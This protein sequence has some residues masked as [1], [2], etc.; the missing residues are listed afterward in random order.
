MHLHTKFLLI[1]TVCIMTVTSVCLYFL[2]HNNPENASY[3]QIA[4][5]DTAEIFKYESG[6]NTTWPTHTLQAE[7]HTFHLNYPNDLQTIIPTLEEPAITLEES[8]RFDACIKDLK[9]TGIENYI[10]DPEHSF[11][12]E[13][14]NKD[15][16][17]NKISVVYTYLKKE[18]ESTYPAITFRFTKQCPTSNEADCKEQLDRELFDTIEPFFSE[19]LSSLVMLR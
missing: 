13:Q 17:S 8:T 11:C 14:E 10:P 7:Y 9:D 5:S 6:T 15:I 1:L 16:G 3:T 2:K 19:I 18:N 12:L 4:Q